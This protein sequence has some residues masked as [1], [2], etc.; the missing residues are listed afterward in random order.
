MILK[1]MSEK[2][3]ADTDQMKHGLSSMLYFSA[4]VESAVTVKKSQQEPVQGV[5]VTTGLLGI[6]HSG[7]MASLPCTHL[8]QTYRQCRKCC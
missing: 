8:K 6:A 5:T 3:N 4:T 2:F 1:H 7:R